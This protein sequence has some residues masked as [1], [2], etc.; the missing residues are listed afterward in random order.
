MR[1][2]VLFAVA[3]ALG[4]LTPSAM[5]FEYKEVYVKYTIAG[6]PV[7]PEQFLTEYVVNNTYVSYRRAYPNGT[8][9]RFK[10]GIVGMDETRRLGE[11]IVAAGVYGM[12]NEFTPKTV[13]V[14][15]EPNAV[16]NV[17]IDGRNKSIALK[18]YIEDFVPGNIQRVL[19]EVKNLAV[20][21]QN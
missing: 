9:S 7:M 6:G 16:L 2:W 3:L 18:P 11:T 5:Q 19:F 4:C 14:G 12:S 10:E 20:K 17:I 8:S 1:L 13:I 21:L 15:D